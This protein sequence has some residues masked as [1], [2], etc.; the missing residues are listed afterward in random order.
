MQLRQAPQPL[1]APFPYMGGKHQVAATIWQALGDVAHYLEP[2]CG[3]CAVLLA[4]T[5]TTPKIETL[6]DADGLLVNLWRSIKLSPVETSR[7]A[8]GP[9]SELD[10]T[11]RL[12][13]LV[14]HREPITEQLAHDPMWHDPQAAGWWLWG[15]SGWIGPSWCRH[16]DT[17][18]LPRL[19]AP[20]GINSLSRRQLPALG[21][22]QLAERLQHVRIACGDWAR[23]VQPSVL[24][25]TS[26]SIGLLLDPPYSI[27]TDPYS[28]ARGTVWE[29]VCR[30]AIR[31]AT[32]R[33]TIRIV[34]C[35]YSG[36]FRPP[37]GW[38]TVRWKAQ[39][40]YGNQ[41]HGDGRHNATTERLWL[42]PGCLAV[43]GAETVL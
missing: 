7:W 13:W 9:I 24:S 31:L 4:R 20:A 32:E 36:T 26:G 22:P 37:Y 42:S 35:G 3:S 18:Q 43:D 16:A 17:R 5:T 41:A 14:G 27:G 30:F 11:A 38:R 19:A 15:A 1:R 12:K 25:A 33:P 29:D 28:T 6:N 39:G 8:R 40:G 34:L 10:Q 21:L 2:F 23:I